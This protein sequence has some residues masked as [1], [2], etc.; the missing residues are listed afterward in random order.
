MEKDKEQYVNREKIID[1]TVL[2]ITFF[3]TQYEKS[4]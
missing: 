4:K 2:L 3:L 1:I